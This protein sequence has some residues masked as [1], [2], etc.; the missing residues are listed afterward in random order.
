MRSEEIFRLPFYFSTL[1]THAEGGA[2]NRG[3]RACRRS[4]SPKWDN[5]R[6]ARKIAAFTLSTRTP[7]K[8]HRATESFVVVGSRCCYH[9]R[10]LRSDLRW[11]LRHHPRAGPLQSDATFATVLSG[12]DS[13]V[14]AR[15]RNRDPTDR[16][17]GRLFV[18]DEEI[19]RAFGT[20]N[21]LR[22]GREM[23]TGGWRTLERE[24]KES[25]Q[26]V[27]A[28]VFLSDGKW[29]KLIVTHSFR[30]EMYKEIYSRKWIIKNG[31]IDF[32]TVTCFRKEEMNNKKW[33][34]WSLYCK[35]FQER[36]TENEKI[37]RYTVTS[38]WK[39]VCDRK[40]SIWFLY[41][42][43]FQEKSVQENE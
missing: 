39:E 14:R 41:C 21:A 16:V 22:G 13:C 36:S 33:K 20:R 18:C 24:M 40:W 8:T 15:V 12:R 11:F 1:H 35:K 23:N 10:F 42:K 37:D 43:N 2:I 34:A 29:T 6:K 27:S 7:S 26:G 4:D 32:Y 28:V 5:D 9:L 25:V 17:K 19:V 31:R 30:K 3:S 38:F